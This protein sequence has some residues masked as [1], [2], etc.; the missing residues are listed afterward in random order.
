MKKMN[1]IIA[2]LLSIIL[3]GSVFTAIAVSATDVEN[4]TPEEEVVESAEEEAEEEAYE[5][6]VSSWM[7]LKFA[8]IFKIIDKLIQAITDFINGDRDFKAIFDF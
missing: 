4:T 2:L 1:K 6:N 5:I 3:V 7:Q 8:L